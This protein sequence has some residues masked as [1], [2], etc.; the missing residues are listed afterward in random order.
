M[1]MA[2]GIDLGGTKAEIIAIDNAGEEHF[3]HRVPHP[4]GNYDATIETIAGLVE[5][6]EARVGSAG[7]LGICH[8]GIMSPVTG[9]LKGCNS[10]W[11]NGRPF[12]ADL[13]TRLARPIAF[14]NDA[15]CMVMSEATDGAGKGSDVVFGVIL[16]TGCGGAICV[17]GEVLP[18][19]N[20][21]A[22]EWGHMPLPWPMD[23]ERPGNLCY[24]GK[25]GCQETW[26]AG[27]GIERDFAANSGRKLPAAEIARLAL[28]G[29]VEADQ[30]LG[31]LEH[32]LARA[33]ANV[34]QL[35]D[36]DVIVVGGGVSNIQR[37][38]ANVP[39]LWGEFITSDTITTLLR[40]S[41]YGD[42]S[43]VRGAAWLGRDLC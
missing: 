36:P 38:Y 7:S 39:Q 43:G 9:L 15:N 4:Q 31:R 23:D 10:T 16:G 3:R 35:L 14:G 32:R 6:T 27:P 37:L 22:G 28:A 20:A 33:L 21:I 25:Y 40:S 18:G 8:P 26:L 13:C 41:H 42:S 19:A 5:L 1:G 34:V 30:S 2:F 11:L 17:N 29:D 24:C 12:D